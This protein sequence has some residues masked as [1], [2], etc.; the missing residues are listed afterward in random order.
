MSTDTSVNLRESFRKLF[1]KSKLRFRQMTG[2]E[3]NNGIEL[4][5]KTIELGGWTLSPIGLKRS[6]TV[7]SLGV[8]DDI[9]FDLEIIARFDSSLHA[10]DPTP[11]W[12]EWIKTQKLPERFHFHP[13]AIGAQDGSMR[14]YPRIPKKGKKSSTMMT[15]LD[16]SP[17][18]QPGID[19]EVRRIPSIMSELGIGNV[20]IIKM[21][22]EAA[23]YEVIDDL[24][25]SGIRPYQLLIEFHHRFK[26]VPIEKTKAALRK[27]HAAG[28]R[29]IHISDKYGEFSFIH[30][31]TLQERLGFEGN[32]LF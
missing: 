29:I 10:F 25:D 28:Y 22:I 18:D 26:S 6:S 21:D 12:V 1:K 31:E 17:G 30:E 14:M 13:L 16:E 8:A 19:V 32:S 15:I 20:D 24:V 11:R 4:N 2:Q 27:L 5:C 23:E 7:F 9:R 3:L